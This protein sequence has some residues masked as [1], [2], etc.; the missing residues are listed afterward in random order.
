[1]LNLMCIQWIA[2][3]D[4]ATTCLFEW[5]NSQT[6]Q[7]L[8]SLWS[9][10]VCHSFLGGMQNVTTTLVSYKTK[11]TLTIKSSNP[12]PFSLP[13]GDKNLYPHKTLH[14]DVSSSFTH[15][16]QITETSNMSF[17]RWMDPFRQEIHWALKEISYKAMKKWKNHKCLLLHER[18]Q[19][20]KATIL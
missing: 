7:I 19:C 9:N 17:S 10:K 16:C 8:V 3:N 2:N 1:M 20:E 4:I 14:T 12:A 6:H 15:N 18:G 5:L 13:K 11:H